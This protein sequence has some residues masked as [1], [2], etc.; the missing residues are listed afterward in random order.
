MKIKSKKLLSVNPTEVFD[1]TAG[2]DF[3]FI[4]ENGTVVH[5]CGDGL[6]GAIEAINRDLEKFTFLAKPFVQEQYTKHMKMQTVTN[7]SSIIKSMK[8]LTMDGGIQRFLKQEDE[9]NDLLGSQSIEIPQRKRG[10][11]LDLNDY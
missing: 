2:E 3:N 8:K 5:N 9:R 10:A 4:L 7:K 11:R 1:I 6:S